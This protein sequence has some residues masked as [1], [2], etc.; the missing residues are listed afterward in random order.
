MKF[1]LLLKNLEKGESS[2]KLE[3]VGKKTR[4]PKNL[5]LRKVNIATIYGWM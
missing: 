1:S 5:Q 2:N 4:F 3:N